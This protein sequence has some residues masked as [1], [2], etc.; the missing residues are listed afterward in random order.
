MDDSTLTLHEAVYDR[1]SNMCSKVILQLFWHRRQHR[2]ANSVSSLVFSV[3]FHLHHSSTC[4]QLD[5]LHDGDQYGSNPNISPAVGSI[6]WSAGCRQLIGFFLRRV[7]LKF[8]IALLY[9]HHCCIDQIATHWKIKETT[10]F[11]ESLWKFLFYVSLRSIAR[12]TRTLT[13]F[14]TICT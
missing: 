13:F 7:D 11:S 14:I 4:G 12:I 3:T 5:G 2:C 10:K 1:K 6:Y 9:F 8:L